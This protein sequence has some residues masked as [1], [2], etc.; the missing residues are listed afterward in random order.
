MATIVIEPFTVGTFA[1]WKASSA[2]ASSY[3]ANVAFKEIAYVGFATTSAT[4]GGAISVAVA[5]VVTGLTSL[6]PSS[7]YYLQDT[8]G[9]IGLTPGTIT[10]KA[11]LS[12]STTTA[13][14]TNIF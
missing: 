7:V 8:G 14:I 4:V 11:A 9:T 6:T 12:L 5:G 10:R 3:N 1:V 2:S 13:I